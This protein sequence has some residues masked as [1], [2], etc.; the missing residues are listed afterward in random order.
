M[1]FALIKN[2]FLILLL[3]MSLMPEARAAHLGFATRAVQSLENQVYRQFKKDVLI[4]Y[5]TA[6]DGFTT[7]ATQVPDTLK[8]YVAIQWAEQGLL[9]Q[10]V[11]MLDLTDPKVNPDIWS[12][13][14]ATLLLQLGY[15]A[16]AEP[17][18]HQLEVAHAHDADYLFLKSSLYTQKQDYTA[19]IGVLGQILKRSPRFGKAYLQRGLLYLLSMSYDLALKDLQHAVKFLP[20]RD[21][22]YRQMACLQIGLIHLKVN[23]NESEAQKYIRKGVKLDPDSPMVHEFYVKIQ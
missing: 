8:L 14:R 19:A 16:Q 9:P 2:I 17:L 7:W 20:S 23:L 5:I 13:Y 11:Q 10:A 12:F 15:V 18:V 3:V 6:V 4:E 22:K 1:R 21:I